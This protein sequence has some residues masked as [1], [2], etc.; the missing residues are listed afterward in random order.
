MSQRLSILVTGATGNQGG[1]VARMLL[2]RGHVVRGLTRKPESPAATKLKAL[3]AEIFAGDMEDRGSLAKA[4]WGMDAVFCVST[5]F[6]SG[7]PATEVRQGINVGDAA[8]YCR[9]QHL[10]YSSVPKA[11]THTG[12]P[13]FESKAQIERHI[14]S[15]GIPWT[16][17]G[18]TM[19]M[20]NFLGPYFKPELLEGRFAIP[21]SSSCKL[22]LICLEDIAAFATLVLEHRERFQ[23][24][25]ID[26]AADERT[27]PEIADILAHGLGRQVRYHHTSIHV[28]RAWSQDIALMFEWFDRTGTGIDIAALRRV[29]PE[30]GWHDLG[31]WAAAQSWEVLTHGSAP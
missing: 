4:A 27:P 13:Q 18:P 30:V 3:G 19:F 29:C 12:I 15:L 22:Q 16:I 26:I 23:G 24:Q 2:G 6:A 1:A 28:V 5:P 14:Q 11:D 25:R 9:I 31:Q 20:E 10:V 17:I 7:G 8:Q 21:L